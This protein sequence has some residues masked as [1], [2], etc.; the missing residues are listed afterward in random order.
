MRIQQAMFEASLHFD[1]QRMPELF[2]GFERASE[3][4]PVP[5]P[6]ACAPQAWAA[7]SVLLLLQTGLRLHVDGC[8]RRVVF[9]APRL[10]DGLE[11]LSFYGL[12]VCDSRV[13]SSNHPPRAERRVNVLNSDGAVE[14]VV[15]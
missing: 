14:V 10:P 13:E 6:L 3:E 5:Y 2:C 9:S 11:E 12:T 7:A 8:H 4:A 1:L 15:T